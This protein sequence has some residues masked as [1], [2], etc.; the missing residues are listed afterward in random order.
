MTQI[1]TDSYHLYQPVKGNLIPLVFDS[2]HSGQ[3][4][5]GD[6]A[7][8]ASIEQIQTGCDAFVDELWLP[9]TSQGA[10]LLAAQISRMYIDLNRAPN[11]IDPSLL[12]EPWPGDLQPSEYSNRGMG[13]I[14]ALALPGQPMYKNSLSTCAVVKRITQYYQPYH[15]C[16]KTLLGQLKQQFGQVWHIDCH[17]MKSRGN[18]MNIDDNQP[19]ADIVI[20]D[21]DGTS[22][23][24]EFTAL[25]V[26]SFRQVG[27]R[28]AVNYPYKGGYLTTNY[29]KPK[30]RQHSIQIEINRALYMNEKQFCRSA[31]FDLLQADLQRVTQI[32]VGYIRERLLDVR[33]EE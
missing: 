3:V 16:L 24:P 4:L 27:Y 25:V 19:R 32:V 9:A 5:P 30:E 21:L 31:N 20:G 29:G 14:R 23:D 7:S 6:F 13:L 26:Q 10:S 18:A 8:I 17:S 12:E 11:D 22:T 33:G 28:V 2:P 1:L 15:M